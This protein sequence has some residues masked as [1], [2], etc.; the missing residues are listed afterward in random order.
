[1]DWLVA[2]SRLKHG[3]TIYLFFSF[4]YLLS[5]LTEVSDQKFYF[6]QVRALMCFVYSQL[7]E[8]HYSSM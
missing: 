3:Y 7:H 4:C 6:I 1:M 5:E 2:V 8:L